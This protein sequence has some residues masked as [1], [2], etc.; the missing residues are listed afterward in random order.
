MNEGRD[1][2]EHTLPLQNHSLE[3]VVQHQDFHSDTELASRLEFHSGHAET[4]VSVD[5]DD[6][7]VWS[8]NLRT[9]GCR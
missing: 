8:G 3:F 9:D 1:G 4:G 2:D 5:I 7:L 6:S